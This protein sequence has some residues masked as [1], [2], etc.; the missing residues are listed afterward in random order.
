MK[1]HGVEAARGGILEN[2]SLSKDTRAMCP[3]S[4]TRL[5]NRYLLIYTTSS[6]S[7]HDNREHR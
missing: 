7:V 1:K 5:F 3:H 4:F 2:C 6:E